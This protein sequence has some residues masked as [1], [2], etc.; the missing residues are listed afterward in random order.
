MYRQRT[1]AAGSTAT[2]FRKAV[3]SLVSHSVIIPTGIPSRLRT[4]NR[5]L[6]PYVQNRLHLS[7]QAA[8]LVD[9]F[10]PFTSR[11]SSKVRSSEHPF[12]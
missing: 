7:I 12:R 11:R 4:T 9:G 2:W 8:T 10:P 3:A 1:V 6:S 5:N